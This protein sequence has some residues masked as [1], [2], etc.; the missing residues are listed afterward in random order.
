[1]KVSV[2]PSEEA[3]RFVW[4][5]ADDSKVVVGEIAPSATAVNLLAEDLRVVT[6]SLNGS[7]LRGWPLDTRLTLNA[8]RAK[9][10]WSVPAP[11]VGKLRQIAVP[12]G[13]YS[14]A[15]AAPRHK[16]ERRRISAK[17]T[18]GLDQV[19]LQPLPAISG[20]V[21]QLAEKKLVPVNG[22]QLIRADGKVATAT[23]ADGSFR[24]ELNE[25]LPDELLIVHPG[26]ATHQLAL[27][28]TDAESDTGDVVLSAGST[29][30]LTVRQSLRDAEKLRIRVLKQTERKHELTPILTREVPADQELLKIPNVAR[31]VYHIVVEGDHPLERL[32]ER[33]EI[34]EQEVEKKLTIE[35]YRL[36]G[37]ARFGDSP[38]Q[39]ALNVSFDRAW[40]ASLPVNAEGAFGATLWQHGKLNGWVASELLGGAPY[41][42]T[43]PPLGADP[44]EWRIELK[45]RVIEGRIVDAATRQPL[46][47]VSLALQ[48]MSGEGQERFQLSTTVPVD[49][50]G[51][52]KVTA[53]RDATYDLR[54]R[55][56]D[57]VPIHR[58]VLLRADDVSQRI[59][60]ALEEGIEM[61]LEVVWADGRPAAGAMVIEGV[62]RD[63]HNPG[64]FY[65]TD[66]AGRLT[67]R[68]AIGTSR[69]LFVL[70][71]EGSFVVV[72]PV[73][74]AAGAAEKI[75]RIVVPPIAGSLRIEFRNEKD[76][77]G[78]STPLIRYNGEWI[79]L[80]VSMR[81]RNDSPESGTVRL[82]ELP[83][84]SYEIWASPPGVDYSAFAAGPPSTPPVRVGLT[85][86]EA[87]AVVPVRSMK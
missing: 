19:V 75:T 3:R 59:D 68:G 57:R 49:A 77:P 53:V 76:D 4:T 56:K 47:N 84:G 16:L 14:L 26:L 20:R 83:A 58:A 51:N 13:E 6:L 22:A 23:G 60:F 55:H 8:G 45:R 73:T 18:L 62:R 21:V 71:R 30:H 10:D 11:R 40:K 41:P 50:S 33:V 7:A 12:A 63:G 39:G 2:A 17:Q 1:M 87:T 32:S 72:R 67:L 85:A 54:I 86:G 37:I 66:G 5:Q 9:W 79:P 61:Q 15:I 48:V 27:K 80:P 69:T 43:S 42:L 82:R 44:S 46:V 29:L 81:L 36:N 70:P 74:P 65:A 34:N 52:Y 78:R 38:L 28:N 25:P 35:P 31:G 24:I 64:A